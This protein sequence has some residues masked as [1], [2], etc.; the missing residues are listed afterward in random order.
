[1]NTVVHAPGDSPARSRFELVFLKQDGAWQIGSARDFTDEPLNAA[2][3]MQQLE[4][5]VG[6]WIDD[7]PESL[8]VTNYH[9]TDNRQ[10]LVGE[11]E[12]KIKG[13]PAMSGTHRLGWDPA[14]QKLHSWVFDSEGGFAEGLWTR[15]ENR[16]V[17]KMNGVTRDGK[18][19]SSTNITAMTGKDRMT[20]QSRDRIVGD[21][22]LPDIEPIPIVR[23]PP[24]PK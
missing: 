18:T 21:D 5:L 13:R 19:A 1:M 7:S 9:W 2:E 11:F 20:W 22:V 23:K 10:F 14:E 24:Q 3:Q 6:Q 17:A 15:D 4:W 16:W 12:V 8:I